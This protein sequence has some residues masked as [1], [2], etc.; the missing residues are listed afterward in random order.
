[1]KVL[2]ASFLVILLMIILLLASLAIYSRIG[3]SSV[4]LNIKGL[5]TRLLVLTYQSSS[6]QGFKVVPC[7]NGKMYAR[8]NTDV[9][10]GVRIASLDRNSASRANQIRLFLE[11]GDDINVLGNVNSN[12]IGYDIVS[13]NALSRQYCELHKELCPLFEREYEL[14][15][16][17]K[18]NRLQEDKKLLDS[19]IKVVIPNR[20][21][22]FVRRHPDYELSADILNEDRYVSHDT[23]MQY[24]K[25]L[26]ENV[27]NHLFGIMLFQFIDGW[28]NTEKG[29]LTPDF[30]EE[31]VSGDKISLNG[32]RGKYVILDFWG[33]WCSW[34]IKDLPAMK[35]CYHKYKH[36]IVFVGV[37]C[38]DKKTA[39][40]NI[41]NKH[42][43]EWPNILDDEHP[44]NIRMKYGISVFP[45]KVIIGKD[46]RVIEKVVGESVKFYSVVDSLMNGNS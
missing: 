37:A 42:S 30:E 44:N 12:S 26:T 33:S 20:K 17:L 41:V 39:L 4:K 22:G 24:S 46:G 16:K 34:C 45:T 31:T 10:C 23:I 40:E 32:L 9:L 43:I 14:K 2:K 36:R 27:R 5:G 19:L 38:H 6:G 15:M 21:L 25:L 29:E 8:I 13:G 7:I 18:Q 35:A 11:P 28:N 1:M 3:N